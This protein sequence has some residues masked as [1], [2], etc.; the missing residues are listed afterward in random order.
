MVGLLILFTNNKNLKNENNNF[1]YFSRWFLVFGCEIIINGQ[2]HYWTEIQS[3]NGVIKEAERFGFVLP[4]PI[5]FV[6]V[7]KT[8]I[9]LNEK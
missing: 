8:F 4:E 2:R 6:K 5:N 3:N 7:E 9:I 1:V